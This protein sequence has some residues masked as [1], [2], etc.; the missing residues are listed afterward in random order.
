MAPRADAAPSDKRY[1]FRFDYRYDRSKRLI[2]E[3][4]Y[5]NNG[6]LSGR[7]AYSYAGQIVEVVS[8]SGANRETQRRIEKYNAKG[9][10]IEETS[11][12]ARGYSESITRCEYEELDSHGN[13]LRRV[14]IGKAGQY[15]GGQSDFRFTNVRTITYY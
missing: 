14:L 7:T 11:P 4:L 13:W 3:L 2:E 6:E 15:G 10:M 8:Y 1:E 9:D 12:A 5:R